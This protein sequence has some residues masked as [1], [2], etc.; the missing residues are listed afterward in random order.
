MRE[1][2][3]LARTS[4]FYTLLD[5]K[6]LMKTSISRTFVKATTHIFITVDVDVCMMV[7]GVFFLP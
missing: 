7:I 6:K 5:I 2:N 4:V 3:K 1:V